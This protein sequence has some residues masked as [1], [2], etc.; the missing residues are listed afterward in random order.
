LENRDNY[1]DWINAA[2]F[3]LRFAFLA[4]AFLAGAFLAFFFFAVIG[5]C[6]DSSNVGS[7]PA[8]R[9]PQNTNNMSGLHAI[10]QYYPAFRAWCHFAGERLTRIFIAL[11]YIVS[12]QMKIARFCLRGAKIP[13][14][15]RITP[16]RAD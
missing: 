7:G 10:L 3:F 12:V 1:V 6:N 9:I 4:F 8:N 14:N 2:Y 15:A 5:M 16:H 13:A 11:N